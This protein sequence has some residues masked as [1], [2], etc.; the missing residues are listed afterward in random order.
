MAAR[1]GQWG[2]GTNRGEACGGKRQLGTCWSH[3][4]EGGHEFEP[5]FI[6]LS[7]DKY[8]TFFRANCKLNK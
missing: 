2:E 4:H 5:Q 8:E 3:V 7:I 6:P 1:E